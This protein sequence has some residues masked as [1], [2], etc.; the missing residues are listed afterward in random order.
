MGNFKLISFSS[1][2]N[3]TLSLN[4]WKSIISFENLS[5][6]GTFSLTNETLSTNGTLLTN[7]TYH[8]MDENQLFFL[9]IY[10]N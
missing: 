2:T 1:K 4:G 6:N 9:K 3:G 10:T 5:P 7:G 8:L